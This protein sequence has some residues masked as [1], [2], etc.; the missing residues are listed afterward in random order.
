MSKI[1]IFG[2]T[3]EGR[4][5]AGRRLRAGDEVVVCVTSE[6]ARRLLPEGA[7]VLSRAMDEAE[8]LAAILREAPDCILDAT[9]PFAVRATENIAA[10]AARAGVP[11]RRI[12][13][14]GDR[15]C[16]WSDAVEWVGGAEEA[17][18]ALL[19]TEGNILLTTG[20]HTLETYAQSIPGERL[21]ARVLP[22]ARVLAHCEALDLLPGHVIA[23]QGPFSRALNAAMYDQ[24][25]IRA[26]VSKDSGDAGG[27]TDKVLPALARGIH[28]I[29]IERPREA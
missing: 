9:H 18:A 22:T 3:V 24:L 8:M 23:M 15:R 27:V 12:R 2:G 25:R 10:C 19:R 4:E 29:M 26:M 16:D 1:L 6:Y 28:V 21:Y 20:S 17:A 13:R 5:A 11:Y 7:R 14:A